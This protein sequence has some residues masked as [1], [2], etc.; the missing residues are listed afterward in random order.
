MFFF[1]FPELWGSCIPPPPLLKSGK[2]WVGTKE[3]AGR[4][5]SSGFSSLSRDALNHCPVLSSGEVAE[6]TAFSFDHQDWYILYASFVYRLKFYC[7]LI[8]QSVW[9]FATPRTVA[10][11]ALLFMGFSGQK[12]WSALPF[13]PPGDLANPR[14][15]PR[16]PAL[17]ADSFEPPGKSRVL[18]A[19]CKLV[20]QSLEIIFSGHWLVRDLFVYFFGCIGS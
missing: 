4:G 19:G 16:S 14:I 3:A 12:H 18:L 9:L 5:V 17:Q 2:N 8:A 6:E 11:Q 13:P 1:P 7:V 15:E 20:I 10:Y